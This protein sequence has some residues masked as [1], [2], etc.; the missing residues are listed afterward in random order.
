MGGYLAHRSPLKERSETE[1]HAGERTGDTSSKEL[2]QG[3]LRGHFAFM[4]ASAGCPRFFK[5][6][7]TPS[8]NRT[9][10]LLR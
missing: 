1:I 4:S 8:K 9:R 5:A 3:F 6:S 10:S 2:A 7:S